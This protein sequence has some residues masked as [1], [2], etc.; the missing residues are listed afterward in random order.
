MPRRISTVLGVSA[1]DLRNTGAFNGFVD[2]DSRLYVDPHLLSSSSTPELSNA[3]VQF[4]NHFKNVLKLLKASKSTGDIFW[5][6]ARRMLTF[7]EVPH[8]G[9]GYSKEDTGGSGVGAEL[10]EG[11]TGIARQIIDAGIEDPDIFELIGLLQEG[12]GADRISD[13]TVRIILPHL[14]SFSARVGEQIRCRTGVVTY[15]S[16]QYRIPLSPITEKP[17]VL[18]PRDILRNLPVAHSWYDIDRVSAHNASLRRVVNPIIG[19]TWKH[20]TGRSVSKKTLRDTLLAHPELLRD[21]VAQYRKKPK[22]SYDFDSDP[23]ALFSWNTITTELAQDNP[24][25]VDLSGE[26]NAEWLVRVVD[27][28]CVSFKKLVEEN[29]MSRLFYNDDGTPRKEKIAQL[30]FYGLCY[31][32]CTA[33]NLDISPE[34]DAGAGP[35]DFKLSHGMSLRATVEVKLSSNNKLVHGYSVQLP[36]YASAEE[37][38]YNVYLVLL[39]G[40]H[41]E[42]IK[43]LKKLSAREKRKRGRVPRILIVDGRTKPSASRRRA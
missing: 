27:G 14:L 41:D 28:M 16:V 17:L 12:L 4:E 7:K 29:R 35:V 31:A 43:E 36:A 32:Y 24:L 22:E 37:S 19:R 20:A 25:R 23:E 5:K 21:M 30:S 38:L 15:N 8:T 18:V 6:Q 10:A 13:M 3:R 9:L 39:N 1:E 33:N 34:T 11:L 2:V 40:E 26:H 42:R